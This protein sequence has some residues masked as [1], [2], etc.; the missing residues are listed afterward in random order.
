M[1]H[2]AISIVESKQLVRSQCQANIPKMRGNHAPLLPHLF[3]AHVCCFFIMP[4]SDYEHRLHYK[5][6][7]L[8]RAPRGAPPHI[9]T[10]SWQLLT[11]TSGIKWRK[12]QPHHSFSFSH[13][14][15]FQPPWSKKMN[16]DTNQPAEYHTT[17]M[18]ERSS[19]F[20]PSTWIH[21]IPTKKKVAGCGVQELCNLIDTA[22]LFTSWTWCPNIC[23]PS[24]SWMLVLQVQLTK[25]RKKNVLG[26]FQPSN[27]VANDRACWLKQTPMML[28]PWSSAA[29]CQLVWALLWQILH[30]CLPLSFSFHP[31]ESRTSNPS[32]RRGV[33]RC[34]FRVSASAMLAFEAKL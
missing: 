8:K 2:Q 17:P 27:T 25:K 34:A 9:S 10:K 18:I 31:K 12:N 22:F 5:N 30:K 13:L 3:F 16:H 32:T 28:S 23:W 19:R 14:P 24:I 4:S 6:I 15:R 7:R 33:S 20:Y 26:S 1:W 29:I 21:V 11:K